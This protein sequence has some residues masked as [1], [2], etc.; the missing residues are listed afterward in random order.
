[1]TQVEALRPAPIL[2]DLPTNLPNNLLESI[3]V[4]N[5]R[6]GGLIEAFVPISL[7]YQE[8]VPVDKAH[9]RELADSI[10]KEAKNSSRTGQLSPVLLAEV[11]DFNMF[12]IIDGF[13]RVP[14]LE[15]VG[16]TEVFATIRPNSTWE[17]II[18]LRIL[19]AITHK[20]VKFSRLIEWVE[21]AWK[22]SQWSDRV[23][24]IQAFTIGYEG[25]KSKGKKLDIDEEEVEEIK[26]WTQEKSEQWHI[27]TATVYSHLAV[28]RLAD[29][30]LVKE[31]RERK[32]GHVL[33]AV[34]PAHLG[35]IVKALPYR[36]D[37]QR[38]AAETAKENA[39]TIPRT[40]ALAFTIAKAESL[41][42]AREIINSESWKTIDPVYGKTRTRELKRQ[43]KKSQ[44][45][46]GITDKE[47]QELIEKFFESEIEVARLTIENAI[48]SGRYSP[49]QKKEENGNNIFNDFVLSSAL[50][51]TYKPRNTNNGQWSED[52][53]SSFV[54]R[55]DPLKPRLTNYLYRRYGLNS[56]DAE[57]IIQ[58]AAIRIILAL[59]N[60]GLSHRAMEDPLWMDKIIF[61]SVSLEAIENY[62]RI[63]GRRVQRPS[64][65]SIEELN[66]VGSI[67]NIGH[68]KLSYEESGFDEVENEIVSEYLDF[69]KETLP[70]LG[71]EERRALILRAFFN[72][73]AGDI[74]VI[75]GKNT[76]VV[77]SAL[78]HVRSKLE[79]KWGGN[80]DWKSSVTRTYA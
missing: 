68:K 17:E 56:F 69:V 9:V 32:S 38:L 21:E 16:Q 20:S 78:S 64:D 75:M 74:A 76:N 62:R 18:D 14:A 44:E 28:A 45:S 73:S 11:P 49:H 25:F 52:D 60:G 2:E 66:Q 70:L 3:S 59:R 57:D 24:A 19:A 43:K 67:D 61:R 80:P 30:T 42:E 51:I 41:E 26:R 54:S 63:H 79:A 35:V 29:P 58:N 77:N 27:S 55:I 8:D 10:S 39:L 47:H 6:E 15:M 22:R 5:R 33:E 46:I 1:M 71:D 23:S 34:T 13:H 53:I 12:P 48:L 7:V 40:R 37:M 36:F 72:M 50:K 4:L 65:R 31:A